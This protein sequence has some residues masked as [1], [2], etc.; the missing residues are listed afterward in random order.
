MHKQSTDF[1]CGPVSLL[2]VEQKLGI[3]GS[4]EESLIVELNAKPKVGTDTLFLEKF[5]RENYPEYFESSGSGS[6]K[7]GLAIANIQN[8]RDGIGHFV[9]FLRKI[10]DG[11]EMFD[12]FDGKV[13]QKKWSEF[14]FSSQCGSHKEFAI[15]F[16]KRD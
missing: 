9:V 15:N 7:G 1:S 13:H 14:V 4:D 10:K 3:K 8:W 12:P 5:C 11:V 2:F 16:K 6:Y